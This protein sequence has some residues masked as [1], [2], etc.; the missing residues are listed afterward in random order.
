[1]Y[2]IYNPHA[3][4]E[5][6]RSNLLDI[7]DIFVKSGYEVTV[8]PTQNSGDAIDATVNMKP[9]YDMLACAGGDGTLDEVVAGMMKR[10]DRIPICYVPA[11]STND[12]ARTLKIPRDMRKAAEVVTSG[13][14]FCCDMGTFNDKTFVYVAAFGMFTDISY[15]TEQNMKNTFGHL[16]YIIE[17]MSRIGPVKSFHLKVEHDGI[18]EEDEYVFGM[19]S[20]SL[21]V[22]GIHSLEKKGVLL[23]DGL[24]EVTLIK[25]PSD[26]AEFGEIAAAIVNGTTN[27]FVSF[28]KTSEISFT[29]NSRIDWT[30]DGEFGGSLKKVRV[31]NCHR[32]LRIMVPSDKGLPR[33]AEKAALPGA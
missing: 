23:D 24:F 29:A 18:V 3:G 9:G 10:E 31:R 11:G 30:L 1:M 2:F 12:F 4:M 33:V 14:E 20:N 28:F 19:V 26:T 8:Y 22:A 7:I 21:S 5:R 27:D 32:A 6:I 25:M 15:G 16:A 17:A 13:V